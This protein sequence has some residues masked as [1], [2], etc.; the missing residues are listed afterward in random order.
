MVAL[1]KNGYS[2]NTTDPSEIEK[3]TED[4]IAQKPLVQAYVIDQVRDK[5]I[6]G[7]AALGVIYSGEAIYTVRENRDLEYVV[8][9]EGSN[10]WIDSWVITKGSKNVSNAE[11]WIDFMCRGDIALK[12]FEYITYST[13]N[14]EAQNNIE[15]EDIKGSKVAFPDLST[16]KLEA[17]KYL[18]DSG[19][20]LYNDAWMKVKSSN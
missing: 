18:G 6:G 17:F 2:L 4:L 14:I 20:K 5:M 12:N 19:D 3:A 7:E 16:M 11:K 10:I 13:P 9:D 1:I 8:P 15:D